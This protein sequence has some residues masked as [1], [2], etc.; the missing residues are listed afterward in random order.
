M[1]F[2]VVVVVVVVVVA[3]VRKQ[4][5]KLCSRANATERTHPLA[6]FIALLDGLSLVSR[7]AERKRARV[8]QRKLAADSIDPRVCG[9]LIDLRRSW[10]GSR[11]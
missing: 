2:L 9:F 10:R 1:S 3:V 11:L 5:N 6:G 7:L 8:V 4:T